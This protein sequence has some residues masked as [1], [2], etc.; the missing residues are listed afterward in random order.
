M[1]IAMAL[2]QLQTLSS[3]TACDISDALLKLKVPHAGFLADIELQHS[4]SSPSTSPLIAPATTVLFARKT[5][6]APAVAAAS[7]L[8]A[9][10]HFAD[11]VSAGGTIAVLSSPAGTRSAAMGGL[12]A[13]R[14]AKRGVV[15]AVVG[16][17]VR[18]VTE[19]PARWEVWAAG[20]ST[21]GA[22]AETRAVAV[23]VPVEVAGVTV[24]AGD[25]VF[26]DAKARGVVVI[27][28]SKL[29]EVLRLLPLAVEMDRLVALDLEAGEGLAAAFKKRRGKL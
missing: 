29:E 2:D 22:G 11:V 28:R 3:Y 6:A 4:P 15:G 8:P 27:P 16:G 21:V 1:Y 10:S 14:M 7:N 24:C 23:D 17:R 18:D 13:Q 19:M 25:I 26:A 9:D 12:V 5:E 20:V